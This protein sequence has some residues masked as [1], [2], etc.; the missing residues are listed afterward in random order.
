[1]SIP[2]GLD[3]DAATLSSITIGLD[4]LRIHD[5]MAIAHERAPVVLDQHPDYRD[6]IEA[7]PAFLD[8]LLERDG[9]IYG[10][11]TGFGDSC[12]TSVPRDLVETLPLHLLR[13]HGC[14]MGS[15][16]SH[17]MTRAVIVVRLISL[18]KGYSGVRWELLARLVQFLNLDA[19]PLMPE[20]GSVGAS[21]DLTPLSYLAAC[22][23]GRSDRSS[24][25][26]PHLV[27]LSWRN[28]I[29]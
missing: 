25:H 26:C 29:S 23:C 10:V 1:M 15:P 4:P 21:G 3:D 9:T 22:R 17:E 20:E 13:F 14:G 24:M 27:S 6:L 18:A 28:T 7:G 19:V 8:K 5:V 16:L 12:N 11:T 2:S